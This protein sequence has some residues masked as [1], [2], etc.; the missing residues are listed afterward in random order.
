[1]LKFTLNL[2]LKFTL[3]LILKFMDLEAQSRHISLHR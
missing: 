2:I 1:M 3:N